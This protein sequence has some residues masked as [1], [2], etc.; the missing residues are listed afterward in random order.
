M[1]TI[2]AAQIA[3]S[4]LQVVGNLEASRVTAANQAAAEDAKKK[5]GRKDGAAAERAAAF[6]RQV[7]SATTAIK[8]YLAYVDSIFQSVFMS[9]FRDI[10]GEIR[11]V[12]V[13]AIGLWMSL[14]P[15]TFL[16][17]T[18]LKYIAWALSDKEPSV[19]VEAANALLK[20]YRQPE[21]AAQLRDFAHRFAERFQEL[22]YDREDHVAVAGVKL[23]TKLVDMEH[24]PATLGMHVVRLMGD[25]SAALR[26]A[27][28]ELAA[29][30]LGGLGKEALEKAV[31]NGTGTGIN[32]KKKGNKRARASKRG[33]GGG[34]GGEEEGGGDD[35]DHPL[36]SH[37]RSRID[38]LDEAQC[39]LT[40]VLRVM[41]MLAAER[42]QQRRQGAREGGEEHEEPTQ[43][44]YERLAASAGP[45]DE[46][47]AALVISSLYSK[48][49]SLQNWSLMMDW[50]ETDTMADV[51]GGEAASTDALTCLLCALRCGVGAAGS[52][53]SGGSS[54]RVGEKVQKER[55]ETRK[56]ATL[57]LMDRLPTLIRK[58]QADAQ[59]VSIALAIVPELKLDIYSV[60]SAEE[61]LSGL[62]KTVREVMFMHA[63]P[64]VARASADAIAVCVAH[65]PDKTKDIARGVMVAVVTE[66]VRDASKAAG[67]LEQAGE[68]GLRG[69][70][71][72][73]Q[74]SAGVEE[75]AVLFAA[76]AA[77]TRLCALIAVYPAGFGDTVE[78]REALS[79]VLE[80][81]A[82]GIPIPSA[83]LCPAA[84][85]FLL[86]LAYDVS[87][88]D[89]EKPDAAAMGR[90]AASQATYSS[91]M[92]AILGE[93][94]GAGGEYDTAVGIAAVQADFM[95]VF[96]VEKIPETQRQVA[97]R[98]SDSAVGSFWQVMEQSLLAPPTP[99]GAGA[100]AGGEAVEEEGE[101]EY[102]LEKLKRMTCVIP[103]ATGKTL[104]PA[105]I[106]ARIAG[107]AVIPQYRTLAA[108]LIS[109]W[110]TPGI[111]SEAVD[112]VAKDLL[113][114]LKHSDGARDQ[115]AAILL[116]AMK[117]A[118]ARGKADMEAAWSSGQA[119]EDN[120]GEVEEE[121]M[122]EFLDVSHKIASTLAVAG[123]PPTSAAYVATEGAKYAVQN[124]PGYIDFLQGVSYFM[125]K[126]KGEAARKVLAEVEAAGRGAGAPDQ[127]DADD[128]DEA[129]ALGEWDLY[130]QYVDA[131]RRQSA[132]VMGGTK[133][134]GAG[135][136]GGGG[137]KGRRISFAAGAGREVEQGDEEEEEGGEEDEG[138]RAPPASVRAKKGGR[139][140]TKKKTPAA[141][142]VGG[143]GKKTNKDVDS[144]E[145]EEEEEGV[146]VKAKAP[147]R[148]SGRTSGRASAPSY[149]EKSVDDHDDSEEEEIEIEDDPS[150]AFVNPMPTEE[151]FG[152][153]QR[154]HVSLAASDSSEDEDDD[155][156]E[157]E[158]EVVVEDESDDAVGGKRLGRRV[159]HR[160]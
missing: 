92:E 140:N 68:E 35:E 158:V 70:M 16:S 71:E 127:P 41:R 5:G 31:R 56:Q 123:A 152:A 62:L 54:A 84:A 99:E 138:A 95:T 149:V 82:A 25:G 78:A 48:V 79:R 154:P 29:G 114:R 36:A 4:L 117:L 106:V 122:Q 72:A 3:T 111:A 53:G 74:Q 129:Q 126:I 27:A 141:K 28:A 131:L 90:L 151:Q 39:A 23:V 61:K 136:G 159:Q 121:C 58:V 91:Q 34:G 104:T 148:R 14:L 109:H 22:M 144:E 143:K 32:N 147:R 20:L 19:R 52:S 75:R 49:P 110:E 76:R 81:A 128:E 105:Q 63:E 115:F 47:V 83:T 120:A 65:G 51:L 146:Q 137:G 87:Q 89:E 69:A 9:R 80:V 96:S 85:G 44:E 12:V 112:E 150:P 88:L 135:G 7:Q 15:A 107:T 24:L 17:A 66:V 139:T 132:M 21:N 93:A 116:S 160:R 43:E 57:A 67:G 1:A 134:R 45:L 30:M 94:A 108:N 153:M 142:K 2:T 46:E 102:S 155:D 60:R 37:P 124:A 59:A 130:Y 26:H 6:H 40:G 64:S 157:V 11:L 18:Y 55:N 118:Y 100:G 73:Y 145:E 33:G 156:V 103:G 77:I 101:E 38:P 50:L 42:E 8:D 98:P 125:V 119:N 133:G 97:Y 13:S 113:R 86:L 10:D